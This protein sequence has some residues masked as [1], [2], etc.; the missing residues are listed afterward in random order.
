LNVDGAFDNTFDI[1]GSDI[2]DY[3]STLTIQSDGKILA[4]GMFT[5]GVVRLD[6]SGAQDGTFSTGTGLVGWSGPADVFAIYEQADHSLLIGGF[7]SSYNGSNKSCLVRVSSTGAL[8]ATF[9]G[10]GVYGKFKSVNA[11]AEDTSGSSVALGGNFTL[12]NGQKTGA[13]FSLGL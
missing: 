1:S 3:V 4:G 12:F 11:I 13:F 2:D 8:D 10:T 6:S 7:F 9:A 5:A